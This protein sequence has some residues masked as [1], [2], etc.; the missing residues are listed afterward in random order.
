MSTTLNLSD[1]FSNDLNRFFIWANENNYVV[2]KDDEIIDW[3]QN[4]LPDFIEPSRNKINAYV[5]DLFQ[6]YKL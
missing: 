3:S 4:I 1:K 6:F 2:K 5:K